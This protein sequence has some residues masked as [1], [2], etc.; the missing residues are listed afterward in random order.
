M[1]NDI[2]CQIDIF[3]VDLFASGHSSQPIMIDKT[4]PVVGNVLDGDRLRRDLQ[5][6]NQTGWICA[7]WQSFYDP[8]SGIKE[9]SVHLIQYVVS[10]CIPLVTCLYMTYN[11]V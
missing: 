3:T 9:F 2:I 7:Q 4:P 1:L 10:T 8:E 11:L 5:Y 6:Q